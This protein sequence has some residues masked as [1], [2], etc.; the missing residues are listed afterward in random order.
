[1]MELL[2]WSGH[3]EKGTEEEDFKLYLENNMRMLN[4]NFKLDIKENSFLFE[5][6]SPLQQWQSW[7]WLKV[8]YVIL[9]KNNK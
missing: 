5:I 2:S 9:H 4:D 3:G 7:I 8:K 1:M 6:I